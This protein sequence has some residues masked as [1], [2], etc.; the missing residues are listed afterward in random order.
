MIVAVNRSIISSQWILPSGYKNKKVK[1]YKCLPLQDDDKPMIEVMDQLSPAVMDSFVHVAVSDSVSLFAFSFIRSSV[2]SKLL[3]L[4]LW[5]IL[6]TFLLCASVHLATQPPCWPPVAGGVVGS[7][8][9]QF[10]RREEPQPCLDLCSV[11]EGSV[12]AMS[13]H[14]LAPGAPAQTLP[15]RS[16]IRLALCF[17][18][19]TAAT[20]T[21]WPQVHEHTLITLLCRHLTV[22]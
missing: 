22:T 16:G 11:C 15:H 5:I 17:H 2:S 19:A 21:G 6:K 14:L 9:E 8:G 1:V 3:V 4:L 10:L 18:T 13:A 12:G 7:T 20:T